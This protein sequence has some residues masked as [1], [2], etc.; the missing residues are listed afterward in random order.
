MLFVAF[1]I[2]GILICGVGF[3]AGGFVYVAIS[4]GRIGGWWIVGASVVTVIGI[5]LGCFL[6]VVEYPYS[7]T[8]RIVGFPFVSAVLELSDGRWLDFV[9][10]LTLPAAIGNMAAGYLL[11]Y[12]VFALVVR[13]HFYA[14]SCGKRKPDG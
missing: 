2:M 6:S 8:A 4:T 3:F 5:L 9:G 10:P 1:G 11:P 7:P 14:G 12:I 13:R